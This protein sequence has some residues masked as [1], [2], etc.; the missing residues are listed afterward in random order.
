MFIGAAD[1]DIVPEPEVQKAAL[2]VL[3]NCVC[4]PVHRVSIF[5]LYSRT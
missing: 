1:G 2:N 5:L 4:A 3:V